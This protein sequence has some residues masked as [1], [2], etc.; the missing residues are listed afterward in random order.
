MQTRME[1]A[2]GNKNQ[3]LADIIANGKDSL[4]FLISKLDDETEMDRRVENFWYRLYV[5]DM[6]L[7]ILDDLFTDETESRSTL[8]GFSWDDFLE[9]G[10]NREITGEEVLRRYIRRHGRSTIKRRWQKLWTE[11]KEKIFWDADCKC[12]EFD[13]RPPS[14]N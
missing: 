10:D 5:G 4:P 1:D 12:F 3:V 11:N 14:V 2:L 8:P 9:R 13:E 7:I 6:A